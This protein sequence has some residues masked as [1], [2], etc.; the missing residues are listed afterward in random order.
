MISIRNAKTAKSGLRDMI[1][2]INDHSELPTSEMTMIEIGC[3]VGDSTEIF[4]QN[5]KFVHAVDPWLNGY[6]DKDAAS[7]QHPMRVIER[8]FDQLLDIHTNLVKV[9]K[10]SEVAH[11]LFDNHFF[12]LVYV[13]GMHTYDAVK[14]DIKNFI[15]K[16]KNG[17]WLTGHDYQGRFPGTIKA[18]D[19]YQKP[20][21][22]FDDTSWAIRIVKE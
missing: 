21:K 8:Q 6:D 22:T 5:F 7:W 2:Y 14:L 12:D 19:E 20:D 18:V 1:K 10:K 4:A 16:I 11:H 15:R 3:Y 17:G 13:D 9:K